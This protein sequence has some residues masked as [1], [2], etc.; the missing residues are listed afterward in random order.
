[1]SEEEK[2]EH[3]CL[4]GKE[5]W[6]EAQGK[7]VPVEDNNGGTANTK[8]ILKNIKNPAVRSFVDSALA[9]IPALKKQI[10][11][12]DLLVTNLTKQL[13][14]ANDLI[15]GHE[16]GQII[17]EIIPISSFSMTDLV[18]KTNEE[19]KDIKTILLNA[20]NPKLNS[21]AFGVLGKNDAEDRLKGLTVGDLSIVTARKRKMS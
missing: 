11:E 7:C 8:E 18:N 12:R 19:L 17:N 14:E 10:A 4:I 2:D 15:K 1:M 6:D 3:G 5:K 9:E 16:K 20:K 13:D 21:V